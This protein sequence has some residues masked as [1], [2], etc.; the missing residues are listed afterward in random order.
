MTLK[1]DTLKNGT[2]SCKRDT[3]GRVVEATQMGR[4]IGLE[5]ESFS[6]WMTEAYA[7]LPGTGAA[8]FV[9]GTILNLE[10]VTVTLTDKAVA[11][12]TLV[13][14]YQERNGGSA[15]TNALSMASSLQMVQEGKDPEDPTKPLSVPYNDEVITGTMDVFA[16][17]DTLEVVLYEKVQ[18]PRTI[19]KAWARKVNEFDWLGDPPGT[20]M[21]MG[22]AATP[23]NLNADPLPEWR[24]A[25]TFQYDETGWQPEFIAKNP[26]TG[27]AFEDV[28]LPTG[29][30]LVGNGA[31][32]VIRYESL[33]F[34]TKF[35]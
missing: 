9:A 1:I 33:D 10:D 25:Y 32:R 13:Y 31:R 21:C 34:S 8:I 16:P 2:M 17:Q 22:V 19:A 23:A 27:E 7:Q 28:T 35:A 18:N 26:E 20:W 15:L 6:A 14:R 4:I 3:T 24:L 11:D 29:G 30:S 12:A 5:G